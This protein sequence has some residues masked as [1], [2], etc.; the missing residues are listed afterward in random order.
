MSSVYTDKDTHYLPTRE[1][2]KLYPQH[3]D[4]HHET[5]NLIQ[6]EVVKSQGAL[7]LL[8]DNS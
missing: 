1:E 8:K 2:R 5:I 7:S 4:Y 6:G 3:R